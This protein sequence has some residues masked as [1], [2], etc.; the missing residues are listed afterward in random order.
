MASTM[1]ADAQMP[2]KKGKKTG[3]M[4]VPNITIT[5]PD[6]FP[7]VRMWDEALAVSKRTHRP[8]LVFNVDYVDSPSISFRDNILRIK[9]VQDYLNQTFELA[10]N[11]FSVNPPPSVGFDS[12]R[13]LGERLDGL[14][15]RYLVAVRPTALLLRPDSTEIERI[16]HPEQLTPDAFIAKL[17]DYLAGRGTL[18]TIRDAFWH[19]TAN[20]ELRFQYIEKLVERSDYDSTV[21]HLSVVARDTK[22]PALA[23]E[24]RKRLAYMQFQTEHKP[25]FLL[26]W[27]TS[28][29]RTKKEDSLE[30]LN[31]Y[32]DILSMYQ[33]MKKI[34]SVSVW[35]DR[36]FVYIGERDAD[37]L[38]NYAWDLANFSKQYDK[39]LALSNEAIAKKSTDAN[40]YDTRSLIHFLRHELA[41]ASADADK[42]L[43]LAPDKDKDYFAE[44]AEFYHKQ[45]DDEQKAP[46]PKDTGGK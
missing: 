3:L 42:G 31:A 4:A 18:T 44:R 43:S 37:L 17:K 7:I 35:Y 23:K 1:T 10:V 6:Q 34:D 33:S 36:I 13:H 29:D 15:N 26:D 41:E 21:R 24:S 25:I 11:D 19:D 45:L 39:A 38:N 20:M 22:Y 5:Y 14:E 16:T 9:K 8:V 40:F 46:K 32:N 30:T 12:L 28:L 27:M 2:N